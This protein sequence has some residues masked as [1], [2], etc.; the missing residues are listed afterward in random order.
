MMLL[1][2]KVIE[3]ALNLEF[4]GRNAREKLIQRIALA[5]IWGDEDLSSERLKILLRPNR[6]EDLEEMASFFWSICSDESLKESD[7][8]KVIFNLHWLNIIKNRM[9]DK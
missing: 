7:K 8:E 2:N 1:Q 9:L 4:K 6:A 3:S 5:Y